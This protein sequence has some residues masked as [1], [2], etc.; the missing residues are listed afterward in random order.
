MLIS[1]IVYHHRFGTDVLIVRLSDR[2][3]ESDLPPIDNPLLRRLGIFQP[4]LEREDESAEWG[5]ILA[6][7]QL[8]RLRRSRSGKRRSKLGRSR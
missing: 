6:A 4:E 5:P 1:H 2:A 7:G 8:L 3:T